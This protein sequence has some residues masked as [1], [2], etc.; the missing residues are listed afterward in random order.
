MNLKGLI[1]DLDGTLADTALDF[2]AMRRELG[3][4]NGMP[5][6]EHLATLT[7][8]DAIA[9]FHQVVEAHELRGAETATWIGDA[10]T[11]LHQLHA[12]QTPMAIVTRNMRSA[13]RRTV[14]RLGIPIQRV[15]TR[16]DV[17]QVKPHPEALLT[18]AEEWRLPPAQLAYVGDFTFDLQ[19][20]RAAGMHA[21]LWRNNDNAHLTQDA[22]LAIHQFNQLLPL[23]AD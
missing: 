4:H 11:V 1:F 20:A 17:Q 14:E 18:L 7:C 10:E 5:L 21:I 6:L 23:L 13:S 3:I 9:R 8:P 16:E 12:R 19:C 15:L 22:D 2:D